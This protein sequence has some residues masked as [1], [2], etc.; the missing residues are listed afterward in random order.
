MHLLVGPPQEEQ[1]RC[2]PCATCK[3]VNFVMHAGASS[4]KKERSCLRKASYKLFKIDCAMT[5]R[6]RK[7]SYKLIEMDYLCHKVRVHHMCHGLLASLLHSLRS[8]VQM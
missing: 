2:V 5:E 8:Q 3:W 4:S 7:H 6:L 1:R